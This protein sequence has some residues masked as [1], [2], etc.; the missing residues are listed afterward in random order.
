MKI[1]AYVGRVVNMKEKVDKTYIP[2]LEEKFHLDYSSFSHIGLFAKSGGGKSY[3]AG[4]LIEESILAENNPFSTIIID[5]LGNFSTMKIPNK[6]GE[7]EAWNKRLNRNDMQPRGM[8]PQKLKVMIPAESASK[9]D[10][11]MY[12]SI[13]SI[14]A[15]N[16]TED[17]LGYAFGFQPLDSQASLY[18][19]MRKQIMEENKDGK[20]TLDDIIT[21]IQLSEYHPQTKEALVNKLEALKSLGLI[22]EEAPEIYDL[23]KPNQA[24]IFN[25]SMSSQYTNRL[26]VN[27]F[28]KQLMEYRNLINSKINLAK[29]KLEM[30]EENWRQENDWYLPPVRLI[31][32]EAHEFLRQNPVLKSYIKKG[33]NLGCV[34]GFISQS[35]DL[36]TNA[37]ANMSHLFIGPM[38]LSK[39]I[40]ALRALTAT[41]RSPENFKA[42]VKQQ[43]NGCFLYYNMNELNSE[44]R[45]QFRPRYSFHPASNKVE[46]EKKYLILP[47]TVP[48][49]AYVKS[50]APELDLNEIERYKLEADR[51]FHPEKYTGKE[52]EEIEE[53]EDECESQCPHLVFLEGEYACSEDYSPKM[54]ANPRVVCASCVN[55]HKEGRGNFD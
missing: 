26:I 1:E 25:L 2:T 45:I 47:E 53:E 43:S 19:K 50:D 4:I 55:N 52:Q 3:A 33:R 23:V 18:R 51:Y 29:I 48:S 36:D 20:F 21:R 8:N 54:D 7:I 38:R 6:T 42:L 44:K 13:F 24:I 11:L 10:K 15:K 12:D 35:A 32:D 40:T 5:P 30:E 37:F 9:F 49:S 31:I 17:L 34:I 16:L 39:D 14:S 22:T 28:A 41:E 27:F 46:E